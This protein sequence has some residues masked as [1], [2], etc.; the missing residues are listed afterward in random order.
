MQPVKK[1]EII[2]DSVE[3]QRLKNLL[4]EK[5]VRG[6]TIVKNIFGKGERGIKGGDGLT[7][8]FNNVYVIIAC[9]EDELNLFVDSVRKMLKKYGGIC[10]VSDVNLIEH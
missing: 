10:L 2:I 9:T 8:V 4:D 6:Y 5:G 1:V 7:E 3:L